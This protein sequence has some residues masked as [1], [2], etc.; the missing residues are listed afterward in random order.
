MTAKEDE[1]FD[2]FYAQLKED[3]LVNDMCE[4]VIYLGT[5]GVL[6]SVTERRAS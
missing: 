5:L 4:C 1:T 6:S 3:F 2:A